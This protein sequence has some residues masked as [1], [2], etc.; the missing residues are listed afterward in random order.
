MSIYYESAEYWCQIVDHGLSDAKT[1]TPQIFVKFK[2]L[3]RVNAADP[4][5]FD[6]AEQQYERTMFKAITKDTVGFVLDKLE[7]LGFTG[8]AWSEFDRTNPDSQDLT[9]SSIKMYCKHELY[10]NEP[11]ERWDVARG[12][13]RM[14][15][16]TTSKLDSLFG[17]EL[18]ARAQA[19]PKPTQPAP[20]PPPIDS[21]EATAEAKT[22]TAAKGD[23]P[24]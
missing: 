18:R 13:N 14:D 24:F 15:A 3:G 7:L 9:G 4:E 11:K 17:K 20:E 2:V 6:E 5:K 21:P 10:K 1:G 16:E 8:S 23:I 19:K 12:D 22:E